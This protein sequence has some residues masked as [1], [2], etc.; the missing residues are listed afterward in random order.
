MLSA[1]LPHR[2]SFLPSLRTQRIRQPALAIQERL[3]NDSP[4]HKEEKK[5]IGENSGGLLHRLKKRS[6]VA[7]WGL[8]KSIGAHITRNEFPYK[9]HQ[10][11]STPSRQRTRLLGEPIVWIHAKIF[12]IFFLFFLFFLFIHFVE[13]CLWRKIIFS[14]YFF[15][16]CLSR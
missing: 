11:L 5:N 9:M 2:T 14:H 3:T 15:S 4:S 1:C 12:N 16:V 8:S 7:T 6:P 13:K 10:L